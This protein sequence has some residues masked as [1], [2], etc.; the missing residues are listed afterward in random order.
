MSP[1]S[2][3]S[4]AVSITAANGQNQI[5][6]FIVVFLWLFRT[7]PIKNNTKVTENARRSSLLTRK[8]LRF[9][10]KICTFAAQKA[11]KLLLLGRSFVTHYNIKC[12][13]IMARP[14]K[15]IPVLK[16]DDVE[17]F[18]YNLE[19]P[20]P[21]SAEEVTKARETYEKFKRITT[22]VR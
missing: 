19:H 3:F 5:V 10:Y 2:V 4:H 18:K 9:S 17:R 1:T 16:G 13:I 21:V 11:A 7:I 14:I 15:E 8:R 12:V 22:F 6:L 20:T